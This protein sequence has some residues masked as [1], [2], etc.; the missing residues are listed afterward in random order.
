MKAREIAAATKKALLSGEYDF[1]RCNFANPGGL[2]C[3]R[4]LHRRELL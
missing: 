4:H 1:V 2:P 3:S